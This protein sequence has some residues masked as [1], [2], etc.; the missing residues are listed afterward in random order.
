MPNGIRENFD[1]RGEECD[2]DE[3]ELKSKFPELWAKFR[4]G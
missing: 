1:I 4:I 3:S 2:E